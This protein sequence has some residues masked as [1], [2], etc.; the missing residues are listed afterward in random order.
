M[1]MVEGGGYQKIVAK[2]YNKAFGE[3]ED[4]RLPNANV[5]YAGKHVCTYE[6]M[7]AGG[8][9]FVTVT[10]TSGRQLKLLFLRYWTKGEV[11]AQFV[12]TQTGGTDHGLP[13]GDV[14]FPMVHGP[15]EKV[16]GPTSLEKPIHILEGEV[17]F[18]VQ[19]PMD[20]VEYGLALWGDE[21]SPQKVYTEE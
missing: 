9:T 12:I 7:Q 2:K 10:V 18:G 20:G 15:D 14:D 16:I 17:T 13:E 19:D 6:E 3:F 8:F 21:N 11:D 5:R 4:A 1:S